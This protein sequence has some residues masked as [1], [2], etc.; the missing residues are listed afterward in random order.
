MRIR[1]KL[2]VMHTGFS[3][4]LALILVLVLRPAVTGVVS[5]AESE[6]AAVLLRGILSEPG[7]SSTTPDPSLRSRLAILSSLDYVDV[8]RG[9]APSLGLGAK[10]AAAAIDA[11]STA[12]PA[13]LD[14]GNAAAVAFVPSTQEPP[15]FFYAVEVQIP[16]VRSGV[17]RIYL[18]A[19]VAL[20]G[21][22]ALI[23]V[24]LEVLVLPRHVYGPIRRMLAADAAAQEDRASEEI[25]PEA[26][27]PS[28]ELGEIMTS[29]NETVR[30]LRK[31]QEELREAVSRFEVVAT[32]LKRKNHL[33]ETA[34]RNLKDADRLASLGVMSAGIAHELNTPLAVIKGLAERINDRPGQ[35]LPADQAALMLRVVRRLERLSESLLDFAR[36]RPGA[37]TTADLHGIVEEAAVLV[38]LDRA[39]SRVEIIN[40]VPPGTLV[41]CD[42]DRMVQVFVNLIRNGVD[43]VAES[44]GHAGTARTVSV[45]ASRAAQNGVAWVTTSVLD[46]G[47]GLDPEI[48]PRL[49]EPFA[50]TRLDSRGTGLGLAVAEGIVK[51]HGG[52]I[53]AHNRTDRSGA[54]FE[55]MLRAESAQAGP[56]KSGAGPERLI[57]SEPGAAE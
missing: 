3:L 29:R 38:R 48:L 49:F 9:S 11:P 28:D 32:D 19:S 13:R 35:G 24:A 27:I 39:A 50:T 30:S 54:A 44:N 46:T 15:G 6:K 37:P 18:L 31:H 1:K 12:L 22:Y 53:L 43:A 33:L 21:V 51:E 57:A 10:Q 45:S 56:K 23:V 5:R 42:P 26:L 52:I 7:A 8:R 55:V 4:G 17:R 20:L 16:E 14:S 36:A 25:I 41:S 34:E 47:P 2:I 40:H